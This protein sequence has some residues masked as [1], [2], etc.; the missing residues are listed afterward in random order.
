MG[1]EIAVRYMRELVARAIQRKTDKKV[2]TKGKGEI[3]PLCFSGVEGLQ[4][5]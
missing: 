1:F 3:R 4:D 2:R 5:I